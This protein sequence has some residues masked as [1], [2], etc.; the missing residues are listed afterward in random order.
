LDSSL[1]ARIIMMA[2]TMMQ[3]PTLKGAMVPRFHRG[4]VLGHRLRTFRL[5]QEVIVPPAILF[6]RLVCLM[7]TLGGIIP[8]HGIVLHESIWRSLMVKIQN[9][10]KSNMR[11]IL[12]YMTILLVCRWNCLWCNS[13]DQQHVGSRQCRRCFANS[14]RMNSVVK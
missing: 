8:H 9:F 12:N 5:R 14:P 2:R 3:R 11:T 6:L 13:R 10:G 1:M 7:W 4:K